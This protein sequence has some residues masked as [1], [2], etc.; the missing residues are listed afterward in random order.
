MLN[1][2]QAILLKQSKEFIFLTESHK[3]NNLTVQFT[4]AKESLFLF[5]YVSC[6]LN[7]LQI[8]HKTILTRVDTDCFVIR[9]F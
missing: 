9:F 2:L 3:S 4:V 7:C 8:T 1:E 5:I 6:T